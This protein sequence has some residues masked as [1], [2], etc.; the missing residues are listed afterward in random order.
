MDFGRE[1]RGCPRLVVV[2]QKASQLVLIIEPGMKVFD[3]TRS[4]P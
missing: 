1:R 3:P 4:L 2:F